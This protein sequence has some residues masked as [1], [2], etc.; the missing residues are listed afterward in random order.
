ML[1][2]RVSNPGPLTYESGALSIA[3][4]G[5]AIGVG[6]DGRVEKG[7]GV[8]L[9]FY[10]SA[11]KLNEL[12]KD[13]LNTVHLISYKVVIVLLDAGESITYPKS[14]KEGEESFKFTSQQHT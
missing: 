7:G 2:D 9:H 12:Q 5:P 4:R 8:R 1:P 13:L 11:P 10:S 6:R 3:L 14:R